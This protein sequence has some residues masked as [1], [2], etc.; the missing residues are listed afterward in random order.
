MTKQA[1]RSY[2]DATHALGKI[3]VWGMGL[4]MLMFPVA[5]CLH[6]NAWPDGAALLKGILS[7]APM[8]WAVGMIEV[9]TYVPM[10]GAGGSYLGFITGSLTMLKVP[11][12]LAAFERAKVKSGTPEGEAVGTIAVAVSSL[13]TL[14]IIFLGVLLIVPL[15]PILEN[16][17]LAPAFNQLLPALFGGLGVALIGK[18]LKIAAVPVLCMVI[19]FTLVPSLASSGAIFVPVAS[20]IAI[21]AARL[22]YKKGWLDTPAGDQPKPTE[23]GAK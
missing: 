14:S 23:E 3:W 12:T 13:V 21:L 9:L 20:A 10:L 7:I 2:D 6:Y 8:Y 16:P 15:T 5:V 11:C 22:M 18:N 4:M 17:T 19:L 1:T